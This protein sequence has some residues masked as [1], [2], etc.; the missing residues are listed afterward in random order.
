[1][2]SMGRVGVG[3]VRSGYQIH[4]PASAPRRRG[5]GMFKRMRGLGNEVRKVDVGAD[6]S[7]GAERGWAEWVWEVVWFVAVMWGVLKG[8]FKFVWFWVLERVRGKGR[9]GV[10][11]RGMVADV[12]EEEI[13]DSGNADA[14]GVEEGEGGDDD[15]ML[16]QRFLRGE[17]ISDDDEDD[18]VDESAE[19][20][21]EDVEEDDEEEVDRQN[22]AL[23]LFTDLIQTGE[24]EGHHGEMV[25]AHLVHGLGTNR[26]ASSSMLGSSRTTAMS[27]SS[28]GPLTRRKWKDLLSIGDPREREGGLEDL[29]DE[30]DEEVSNSR[31]GYDDDKRERELDMRHVCVVCTIEARDIIC[32]P[33]RYVLPFLFPFLFDC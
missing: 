29:S 14:G 23:G 21:V 2:V 17:N 22:E 24:R 15:E 32:W 9:R 26:P 13:G 12:R 18:E 28:T 11:R 10:L 3:F 20:D 7:Q 25:L 8:A 19:E 31:G 16:Y 33:C 27:P 6:F 1:M 5:R 30:D 4:D